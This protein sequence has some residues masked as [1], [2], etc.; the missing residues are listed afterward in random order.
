MEIN[1]AKAITTVDKSTYSY[2]KTGAEATNLRA[3]QNA[4]LNNNYID[5]IEDKKISK[6]M[7]DAAS[8]LTGMGFSLDVKI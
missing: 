1:E 2:G 6:Q 3:Q 8:K 5:G 7:T 4:D